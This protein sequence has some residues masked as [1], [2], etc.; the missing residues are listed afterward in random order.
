M[1]CQ[2]NISNIFYLIFGVYTGTCAY[3]VS[4]FMV[5]LTEQGWLSLGVSVTLRLVKTK[6]VSS[7]KFKDLSTLC[8]GKI[9]L[10]CICECVFCP[11]AG[12]SLLHVVPNLRRAS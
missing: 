1:L 3:L 8:Q 12:P 9:T 10:L 6:A 7:L 5:S 11:Q 2:M 4:P